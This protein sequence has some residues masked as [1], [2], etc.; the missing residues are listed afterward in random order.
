MIAKIRAI[1]RRRCLRRILRRWEWGLNEQLVKARE[2]I[3]ALED[4]L[5]AFRQ[6]LDPGAK[7]MQDYAGH[8]NDIVFD[9]EKRIVEQAKTIER[10]RGGHVGTL[11]EADVRA[12]TIT[13]SVPFEAFR[14]GEMVTGRE[15]SIINAALKEARDQ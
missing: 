10:L 7:Q 11:V 6:A 8:L 5:F 1:R 14:T 3:K 15:Y 12:R 4:E 13:L 9:F 2:D